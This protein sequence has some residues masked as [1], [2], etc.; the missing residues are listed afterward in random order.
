MIALFEIHCGG[1]QRH[2]YKNYVIVQILM[3]LTVKVQTKMGKGYI[4]Y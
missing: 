4:Q 1:V 2:T 3:D